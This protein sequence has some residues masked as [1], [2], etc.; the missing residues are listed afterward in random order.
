MGHHFAA[1]FRRVPVVRL[2]D[3][4]QGRR[5]HRGRGSAAVGVIGDRGAEALVEILRGQIPIDGVERRRAAH[6][7][8]EHSHPRRIDEI[9]LR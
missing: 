8:T 1:T 3:Q 2:P 4:D 5:R 7:L 6:R 9:Q